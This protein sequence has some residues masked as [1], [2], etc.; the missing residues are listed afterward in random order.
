MEDPSNLN[1][2]NFKHVGDVC[3]AVS[4]FLQEWSSS[5]KLQVLFFF[6]SYVKRN[7]HMQDTSESIML[8]SHADVGRSGPNTRILI[9]IKNHSCKPLK[10]A[11]TAEDHQL[12]SPPGDSCNTAQEEWCAPAGYATYASHWSTHALRYKSTCKDVI[13]KTI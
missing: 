3:L 4:Y 13:G 7:T 9:L 2:F 11:R 5:L 8:T 6:F 1:P 10:I 12:N